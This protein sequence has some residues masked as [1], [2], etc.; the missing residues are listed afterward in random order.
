MAARPP[1]WNKVLMPGAADRAHARRGSSR[2]PDGHISAAAKFLGATAAGDWEEA[3]R[4]RPSAAAS[5]A[6]TRPAPCGSEHQPSL[7]GEARTRIPANEMPMLVLSVPQNPL[8]AYEF[9]IW[10]V[11]GY[12]VGI[13]VLA[14]GKGTGTGHLQRPSA[15]SFFQIWKFNTSPIQSR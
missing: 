6:G 2:R 7:H 10:C 1:L 11:I 12:M 9:L 13:N 14:S 5:R 4:R 8:A 3:A 15:A